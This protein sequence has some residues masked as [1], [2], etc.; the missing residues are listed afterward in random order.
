MA[1]ED[2][3]VNAKGKVVLMGPPPMRR[4]VWW[5]IIV[6]KTVI[7]ITALA[8]ALWNIHRMHEIREQITD[9]TDRVTVLETE[10]ANETDVDTDQDIIGG[11]RASAV[12]AT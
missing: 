10:E 3:A 8:I 2:E 11:V 6:G 5:V 12:A 9:L 4:S 1:G 7:A